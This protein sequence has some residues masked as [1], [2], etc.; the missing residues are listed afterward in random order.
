[1]RG[2][3][4]I[5][6]RFSVG[7]H[8][9][10]HVHKHVHHSH[11]APTAR[12]RPLLF[13]FRTLSLLVPPPGSRSPVSARSTRPGA[14]AWRRVSRVFGRIALIHSSMSATTV[15]KRVRPPKKA[16]G[17]VLNRKSP[18]VC[19]GGPSPL[20]CCRRNVRRDG[21]KKKNGGRDVR[22]RCPRAA[23]GLQQHNVCTAQGA[24][25]GPPSA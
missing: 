9:H 23:C 7:W 22:A 21:S 1:M 15:S 12:A 18:C 17:K 2:A 4:P 16:P 8:V 25:R 10:K 11:R 20:G 19:Y 5:A 6:A 13:V 3:I 24:P 14:R